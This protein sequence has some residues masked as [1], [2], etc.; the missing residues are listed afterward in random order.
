M[1]APGCLDPVSC[2]VPNVGEL[3]LRR[4]G[5]FVFL[6]AFPS[7][8]PIDVPIGRRFS[9]RRLPE[10]PGSRPLWLT[11]LPSQRCMGQ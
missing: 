6:Q 9:T 4:L 7:T 2:E 8:L 5:L 3:D 10:T 1:T 11:V